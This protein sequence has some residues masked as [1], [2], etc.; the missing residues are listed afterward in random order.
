MG[1]N[2]GFRS[3]WKSVWWTK[4][5]LRIAFF[6]WLVALGK[7]LTMDN[8]R[9]RHVIVVGV[10]CMCKKNGEFV[11]LLLLYCELLIPFRI[12]FS[13]DLGYLGLCLDE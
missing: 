2:D 3:P 7:I 10:C 8:L 13:V 5:P 9:K 4:V 12:F 11:D 1:C 6:V